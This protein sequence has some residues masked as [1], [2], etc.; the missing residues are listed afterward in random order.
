MYRRNISHVLYPAAC[1]L[2]LFIVY[3]AWLKPGYV[4]PPSP[5][6]TERESQTGNEADSDPLPGEQ[7]EPAPKQSRAI[8]TSNLPDTKYQEGLAAIRDE[9]EKGNLNE[10]ETKLS[11]LPSAV[12]SDALARPY[13][14]TLW[15]NLGIEQEKHDGTRVSVKA[16]KN[17]AALDIKNPLIQMNLA[18]AYWEQRD[19][20][21][22]KEFLERLIALAP[23]EPFPHLALADLLQERDRLS[24]AARH[25]DQA[26]DRA[27]N[28]P[29]MQSYLRAVT[30]RVRRTEQAE[31]RLNSRDG[32]HFIVKYDGSTDQ[33]TWTAVLEI[34]E[35]AYRE[36]GQKFGHFPS[37]PIVVV[38]HAN[39]TFQGV[40]GS[41]A[42]A[43]G[44]FDPVLGRIQIPTQGALTDRVWLKR[45]LRHEFLHALLQDL[46]GL[47]TTLPTW[48]NEGLAMQLSSDRWSDLEELDQGDVPVLPLTALEGGWG[49]LSSEAASVAYLE[50]NS[51]TRYLIR[52]YGMHEVQQLLARMKKK[53]T[54]ATA[55]QSQLSLSY[56][57]FQSR[58]L[59]QL[60]EERKKG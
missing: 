20:A 4:H 24:E 34:L 17:A 32:A 31:S 28:D 55:M 15:N 46:Q 8:D 50:A 14:A 3:E 10:A 2:G 11:R 19:P 1:I 13:V 12:Q 27:G 51:A 37:K 58:W 35:E 41:P 49:G 44:L 23:D 47:N 56:E 30:A 57:Q 54:L 53:Q 5:I 36:M 21:M 6:H 16:F 22:T 9:I 26:A 38:L 7:P 60:H 25:L 39:H 40:T 33:D 59:E 29:S 43:D 52:R 48:L 18:H 45:V 42:W